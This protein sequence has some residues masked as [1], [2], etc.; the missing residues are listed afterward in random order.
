MKMDDFIGVYFELPEQSNFYI[1]VD[2]LLN[3]SDLKNFQ[4]EVTTS[5]TCPIVNGKIENGDLFEGIDVIYGDKL[6]LLLKNNNYYSIF[7]TI[8]AYPL[9]STDEDIKNTV[10]ANLD[11]FSKSPCEFLLTIIDGYYIGLL[12]KNPD[13]LPIAQQHVKSLGYI[14]VRLIGKGENW[15]ID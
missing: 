12:M 14:N 6:E 11:E 15:Y 10:I 9:S 1:K 7:L 2:D 4:W 13:L 5:D 3:F 8:R